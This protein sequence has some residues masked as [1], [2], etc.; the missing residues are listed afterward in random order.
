[1]GLP[2]SEHR[3]VRYYR[4]KQTDYD[5]RYH[6]YGPI[7]VNCAPSGEWSLVLQNIF[8][9]DELKGTLLLP[10]DAEITISVMDMQGR[11]IKQETTNAMKGSNLLKIEP[12]AIDKGIY[13]LKVSDGKSFIVRKFVR[14]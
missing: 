13:F 3:G 7:S 4:L 11:T 2:R 9:G 10:E 14:Y 8:Y 12:G 1:M 5:G 6:Y